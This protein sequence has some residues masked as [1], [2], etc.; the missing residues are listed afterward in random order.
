M[1][2][3]VG[4]MHLLLVEDDDDHARLTMAALEDDRTSNTVDRV[5]D[6]RSAIDYVRQQ[7]RFTD[8]R[9]PDLILL[10]LELPEAS[11]FEVLE[12]I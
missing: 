11:G 10:D 12:A 9:R 6:G 4:P 2:T 7:G 8:A 5:T 1:A 3:L